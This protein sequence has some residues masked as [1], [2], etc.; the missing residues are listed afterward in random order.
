MQ[1]IIN[2]VLNHE[3]TQHH[4]YAYGIR[5]FN[6]VYGQALNYTTLS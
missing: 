1:D 2:L 5:V 4:K 6:D 3:G